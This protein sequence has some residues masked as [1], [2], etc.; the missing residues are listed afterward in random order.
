MT[1]NFVGVDR[2]MVLSRVR[3]LE[4]LEI[5]KTLRRQVDF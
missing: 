2:D 4:K 3:D 1:E 5:P